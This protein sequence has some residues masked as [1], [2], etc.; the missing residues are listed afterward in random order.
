MIGGFLFCYRGTTGSRPA[1]KFGCLS[2]LGVA[3]FLLDANSDPLLQKSL[4]G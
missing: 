3:L 2:A 4:V 1:A